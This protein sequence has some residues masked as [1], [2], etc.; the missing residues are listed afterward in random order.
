V[1][2]L[3]IDTATP[4]TAVGLL[5]GAGELFEARDIVAP[6]ERGRHAERVLV[7]AR[8]LLAT[9]KLDW[10]ELEAIAV[11]VGPGGYTGLRIGLATARGLAFACHAR[12][13]GVGTLRALAEPLGTATTLA[14]IDARRGELFAG[15]Y[16]DDVEVLAPRVIAP[17]SLADVVAALRGA[18]LLAVGDGALAHRDILERLGVELPD[19]GSPLHQVSGRAIC[20][21]ALVSADSSAAPLYLR[22][23]DAELALDAKR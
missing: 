17:P 3:G 9:A 13:I 22:R 15:A 4:S 5:T 14:L 12:L 8:D 18:P 1:N 19:A 23:P 7:E 20:R 11:G 16:V 6:G 10:S 2:V 21:L